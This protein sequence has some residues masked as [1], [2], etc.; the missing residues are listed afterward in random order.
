MHFQPNST[1]WIFWGKSTLL[2]SYYLD[3]TLTKRNILYQWSNSCSNSEALKKLQ[4]LK[5]SIFEFFGGAEARLEKG[6]IPCSI[7]NTMTSHSATD[8][9][10]IST[11]SRNCGLW[12]QWIE[13]FITQI[14]FEMVFH[15][16]FIVRVRYVFLTH[17]IN[18]EWYGANT[19]DSLYKVFH[20]DIWI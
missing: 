3:F 6:I 15:S 9:F 13:N 17:D 5:V 14:D 1:I 16:Y 18:H 7:V 12:L 10:A 8:E 20:V 2:F 4:V 11:E 19:R